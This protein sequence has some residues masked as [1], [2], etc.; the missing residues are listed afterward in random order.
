[1]SKCDLVAI[2]TER[3]SG[4]PTSEIVRA[5][6]KGVHRG[7]M[8]P[9]GQNRLSVP[10][11]ALSGPGNETDISNFFENLFTGCQVLEESV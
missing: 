6:H 2:T 7:R 5:A 10:T 4:H 3:L 9:P 8:S 11:L 1:M